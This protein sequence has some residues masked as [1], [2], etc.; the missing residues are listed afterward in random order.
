M[1][2]TIIILLI[3]SLFSGFSAVAQTYYVENVVE[4]QTDLSA[5]TSP[6][7]DANG[8]DCAL[9]KINVPSVKGMQFSESVGDI[10]YSPGEIEVYV[11]EGTQRVEFSVQNAKTKS[12]ISFSEYGIHVHGKSVYKIVL[13]AKKTD[14]VSYGSLFV[15]ANVEGAVVLIDGKPAGQIPVKITGLTEGEHD[16]CIPNTVGYTCPDQKVFIKKGETSSLSLILVETE[17]QGL[18]VDIAQPGGDSS[19]WYMTR[20]KTITNNGKVG[21]ADLTG[22]ILV[23]C[24]YDYV[25][26]DTQ[27]GG[28]FIVGFTSKN[29]IVGREGLYKPGHGLVVDCIYR[30]FHTDHFS[31]PWFYASKRVGDKDKYGYVD[32]DGN[33][34][35]PFI[36]DE[37]TRYGGSW[38]SDMIVA[39]YKNDYG[40]FTGIYDA[41]GKVIVA[42]RPV[43][44][45]TD[46]S[47]GVSVGRY[48]S[49][50]GNLRY[51]VMD[52]TG[53]EVFL[54]DGIQA[55]QDSYGRLGSFR[56]NFHP[57]KNPDNKWG[58]INR[59]GETIIPFRY[60]D[61]HFF[62][63]GYAIV[64]QNGEKMVINSKGEK[65]A[66]PTVA[67]KILDR[68]LLITDGNLFGL[69]DE[70][71]KKRL[72]IEYEKIDRT[73][74]YYLAAANGEVSI[75]NSDLQYLF[76]IPDYMEIDEE[77]TAEGILVINDYE[78][79]T[80]GVFN[81]NGEVIG[82]CTF[83][84]H[85]P[86][87]DS[88]KYTGDTPDPGY[89]YYQL[90]RFLVSEEMIMLIFGDRFGFMD[91]YGN[92]TVP[93]KYTAA[94][95]FED[96]VTYVRKQ[97]GEW[98]KIDKMNNRLE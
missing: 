56:Q 32:N 71:G 1:K 7:K 46:F 38:C 9:L 87:Y 79:G 62:G 24:E 25:Y 53:K 58:F 49:D 83:Y 70:T 50:N 72:P 10:R 17:F 5:R 18:G 29:G 30:S 91:K 8:K 89:E 59:K 75:F 37:G 74:D 15:T 69:M 43:D 92:V 31:A 21:I 6:R 64:T 22:N 42:P 57:V 54:P 44:A 11:P 12:A 48:R 36:F 60:D 65:L 35:V 3:L 40:R 33:E 55:F 88:S 67:S 78:T 52:T 19:E 39:S 61:V 20:Y 27:G 68:Y 81:E 41:K 80:Y 23:P 98:I 84:L 2:R 86:P 63:G 45:Q 93:V 90:S 26:P 76:S 4:L 47:E 96:G 85:V 66:S 14:D 95:P 94:F 51:F 97:D 77:K 73:S 16:L 28:Y 34:I 13:R 82:D